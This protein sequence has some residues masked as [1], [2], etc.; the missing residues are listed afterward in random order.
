MAIKWRQDSVKAIQEE[1]AEAAKAEAMMAQTQVA[2]MAFCATATTITDNQALQMPDMFPAWEDVLKAGEK[3]GKG[4]ILRDGTVLYRVVQSGGVVPQEHQPPHGEG[5]LAVYRPIDQSH[6][7]TLEDPI[8]WVYGMDC[9]AGT[10]YS[11]NGH[12]YQVA[13]AGD[14]KPCVWPPDTPGLWQWVLVK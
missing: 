1:K 3:L 11:Y 14:M 6:A 12:V 8:P 5:M 2:V 13:E 7:G 4:T 9:T 10:Y